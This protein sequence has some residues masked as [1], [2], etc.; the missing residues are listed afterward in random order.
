MNNIEIYT[1]GS[2]SGN[3][4]PGGCSAIF[5]FN[6]KLLIFGEGSEYTTNNRMEL[7]AAIK[8][9]SLVKCFRKPKDAI[10]FTDSAYVY[11]TIKNGLPSYWERVNFKSLRNKDIANKDLWEKFIN[12]RAYFFSKMG[13][14]QKVKGHSDNLLNNLADKVAKYF[15]NKFKKEKK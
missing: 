8:A 5:N 15:T 3:P 10:I 7:N 9:I 14:I 12:E 6:N 2:C 13:D 4:G 1:D 11:N